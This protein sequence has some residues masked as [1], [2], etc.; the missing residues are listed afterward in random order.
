M[1][2]SRRNYVLFTLRKSFYD[3]NF[4]WDPVWYTKNELIYKIARFTKSDGSNAILDN[5][6]LDMSE[7]ECK[8]TYTK[9]SSRFLDGYYNYQHIYYIAK[10]KGNKIIRIDESS[11]MAEINEKNIVINK[12]SETRKKEYVHKRTLNDNYKFRKGPVPG[13]HNYNNCHRGDTYRHPIT[14][15]SIRNSIYRDEKYNFVDTKAK[16]LPKVYDDLIR[17]KDKCWK[18]SFKCKKQWQKHQKRH[19]YTINF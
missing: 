12:K 6:S 14:T 3:S 10:E 1:S 9:S 16:N 11:L 19:I 2:H 8:Y 4:K 15:K 13:I 17:H 5:L 18:T 7:T